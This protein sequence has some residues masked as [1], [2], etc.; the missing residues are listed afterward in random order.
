MYG[1]AQLQLDTRM[2]VEKLRVN[3]HDVLQTGAGTCFTCVSQPGT[4]FD[5]SFLNTLIL[6]IIRTTDAALFVHNSL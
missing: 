6:T 5:T 3:L 4:R 1:T 2:R